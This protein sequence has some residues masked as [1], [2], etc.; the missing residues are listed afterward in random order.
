MTLTTFEIFDITLLAVLIIF[1]SIFLYKNKKNLGK[2]GI[3]ILYRTKWGLKLIDKVGTKYKKTLK[4]ISYISII[5]GYLLMMAIIYLFGQ[6]VYQYLFNPEII[7]NIR[8]PPIAP[9]IPYFPKLFGLQD[10]FPEFYAIY[11]V[12]SILIVAT[13]HEFAHG[14]FSRRYGVKIKSTGFAFLKFFPAIFGAF[15]EQ[16]EK[17]M[18]KKTKFEQISILSSGVFAN[19]I[20]A[21][22]FVFAILLFFSIAFTP[23]GVFFDDY[24]YSIV[25]V[26]SIISINNISVN[27]SSYDKVVELIENKTL[28]E[29]KT[30]N[31]KYSGIKGFPQDLTLVA[32]YDDAPAINAG[33][34]PGEVI[35]EINGIKIYGKEKLSEELLKYFPGD[36][37]TLKIYDGEDIRN[38]DI[39]LGKN[40]QNENMPF[41]G[42]GFFNQESRGVSG[43]I[44]TLISSSFK[45]PN[46]YYEPKYGLSKFIYY[47]I[48]WVI[49]INLLVGLMNMLPVGIFDGGKFFYLTVLGITKSE[50]GAKRIFSTVTYLFLFLL[51]VMMVFWVLSFIK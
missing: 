22:L 30:D 38:H 50:K 9:L 20:T 25:K 17:K 10:F 12:I 36:K 6:T 47:L 41:L 26:S 39:I 19:I 32:L 42:I 7:K 37:I 49:I 5:T 51:L 48:W 14:I 44:Y 2:D 23:L 24:F 18:T 29:I 4:V 46:I 34:I 35:T 3:L 21:I 33:L 27:N 11:F 31:N 16:D 1:I 8:A 43:K 45:E 28:N 40:P 13:V 15:V